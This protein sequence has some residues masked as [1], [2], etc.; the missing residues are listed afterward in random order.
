MPDRICKYC[1]GVVTDGDTLFVDTV[2]NDVYHA[3]CRQ[4]F[5]DKRAAVFGDP[6]PMVQARL[7]A[8]IEARL[9]AE[10]AAK[11]LTDG[12]APVEKLLA[13]QHYDRT[14]SLSEAEWRSM[15]DKNGCVVQMQH[16][17]EADPTGRAPGTPGAKLDAGKAPM[18][19]GCVEYFPLALEQVAKVSQFGANKYTWKGWET[20]PDGINR[21]GDALVRHLAKEEHD[22]DSGLLHA[23]HAAWN[24]LARLELMLRERAKP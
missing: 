12:P 18:L 3:Y 2:K 1:D 4:M 19:R 8:D 11:R 17:P 10:A 16:S 22:P 23:A 15:K 9:A 24:A 7:K 20:V 14:D 5:I 21:Y 13:A 6:D